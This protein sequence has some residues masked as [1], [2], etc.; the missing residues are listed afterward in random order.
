MGRRNTTTEV[1][2]WT[3]EN[4]SNKWRS[5]SKTSNRH[6]YGFYQEG[7][8]TRIKDITLSSNFPEK[9][10][11]RAGIGQLTMYASGRNLFTWPKWIG[12]DPDALQISRVLR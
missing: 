3:A 12:C 11:S 9:W 6:G 1:G 4:Q 10:L 5:L 2:Y 7:G 8:F